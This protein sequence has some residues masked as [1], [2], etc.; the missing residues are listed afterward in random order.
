[1]EKRKKISARKVL[2]VSLTLLGVVCCLIAI[3]SA[4]QSQRHKQLHGV[5]LHV[6]NNQY[7]FLDRQGLIAESITNKGIVDRKTKLSEI[8]LKEVEFSA[9]KNPWVSKAQ[10]YVDSRQDLHLIVTQCVPT[11]R[12]FFSNGQ[13]AYLDSELRLLPLSDFFTYYT[14]VVTNVPSYANDTFNKAMRAKIVSLVK[15]IEK[16]SFWNAQISQID[17]TENGEF[18]LIPVFGTQKILFGDTTMMEKKFTNLFAFY[19]KV[20]NRIGWNRYTQLDLRFKDQI[21][22]SPSIPWH[23]PSKNAISNMDWVQNIIGDALPDSIKSLKPV[24]KPLAQVPPKAEPKLSVSTKPIVQKK[25]EKPST[26]TPHK[27]IYQSS[28]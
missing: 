24:T 20:L 25:P 8:K 15:F 13:S 14:V 18:E 12:I 11:A 7:R 4:S 23:P 27:Y 28:H 16:D 19:R 2:R 9:S 10:A 5:L 22:A 17:V 1:M 6:T 3:I 21:V 26:T